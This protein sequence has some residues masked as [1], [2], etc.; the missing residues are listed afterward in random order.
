MALHAPQARCQAVRVKPESA[1]QL[2]PAAPKA[3]YS[4]QAV[5]RA[6]QAIHAAPTAHRMAGAGIIAPLARRK[7]ITLSKMG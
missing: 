6:L 5:P 4:A 3:R 2:R 1:L 7:I